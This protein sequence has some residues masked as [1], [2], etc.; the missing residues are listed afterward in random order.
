MEVSDALKLVGASAL[1]IAAFLVNA[2]LGCS[3]LGV[4]LLVAGWLLERN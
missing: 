1:V 2:V 4:V 3:V